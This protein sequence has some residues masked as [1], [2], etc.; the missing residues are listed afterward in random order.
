MDKDIQSTPVPI[1]QTKLFSYDKYLNFFIKLYEANKLPNKM[2]FSGESGIGKSTFAYHLINYLF[3]KKEKFSYDINS[4]TIN[5]LN[6]SFSLVKQNIHPNFYL[7]DLLN[8]K[9]SIDIKQIRKMITYTNK[10]AFNEKVKFVLIDNIEFLNISSVNSLL[11]VIEEPNNNTYFILIHNSHKNIIKTLRSRCIDF[12]F[13]FTNDEKKLIINKLFNFNSI[14]S[15]PNFMEKA[16]SFYDSPGS[17]L[18]LYLY[19]SK[20]NYLNKDFNLNNIIVD[21]LNSDFSSYNNENFKLFIFLLEFSIYK[22]F[23]YSNNRNKIYD[24]YF[25][26]LNKIHVSQKYNLDLKNLFFELKQN[27]I[28]AI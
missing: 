19:L 1:N 21:L 13:H 15:N 27:Y 16:C 4:C 14:D 3:S 17:I 10:T 6:H 24:I 26:T 25:N 8:N 5:E 20:N 28:N 2:L 18:N 11:K 22:K 23:S 7:I 9:Q 12:K